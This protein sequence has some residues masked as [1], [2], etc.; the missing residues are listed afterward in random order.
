MP[1]VNAEELLRKAWDEFCKDYNRKVQAYLTK[2]KTVTNRAEAEDAHWILWNEHD[3]MMQLS[4]HFYLQLDKNSHSGIEMH[5]DKRLTSTNF[6]IYTF[7]N[8]LEDL[9]SKHRILQPDLIIADEDSEGP[10]LLCAEAKCFRYTGW[11]RS[12]AKEAI[13]KDIETLVEIRRR[14]IAESVVF[15]MFDD[16]Y[17][18]RNEDIESV[19]KNA[20]KEHKIIPLMHNSKAKVEPWK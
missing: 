11:G 7:A 9:H 20:C 2:S 3:L 4:R 15:I 14:K 16:Y 6:G 12:A 10:F 13:K 18:I 17:W 5:L 1:N 19:V 8:E